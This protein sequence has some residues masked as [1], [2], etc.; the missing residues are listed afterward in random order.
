MFRIRKWNVR[1]GG[2]KQQIGLQ[3]HDVN[4]LDP[5]VVRLPHIVWNESY[6]ESVIHVQ[7]EDLRFL[8]LWL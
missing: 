4:V 1:H 3:K 5:F 2:Q 7:K 6:E 8:Q